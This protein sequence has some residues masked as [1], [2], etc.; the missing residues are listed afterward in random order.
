MA[1]FGRIATQHTMLD[2]INSVIHVFDV[3]VELLLVF[4]LH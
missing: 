2:I 1:G 4:V 3:V